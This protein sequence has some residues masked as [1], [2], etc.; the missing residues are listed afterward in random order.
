MRY[1]RSENNVELGKDTVPN[2][3]SV[4]QSRFNNKPISNSNNIAR[5]EIKER[6]EA[7]T[8]KIGVDSVKMQ[9]RTSTADAFR[10]A[11]NGK[12]IRGQL[13]GFLDANIRG[14]HI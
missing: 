12:D 13:P 2:V 9:T 5:Q 8:V 1:I 14:T 11:S 6:M 4:Y 3:E 10:N 7:D